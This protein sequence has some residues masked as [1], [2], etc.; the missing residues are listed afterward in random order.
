MSFDFVAADAVERSYE[1][2]PEV[3][4]NLTAA[5]KKI[6]EMIVEKNS[7]MPNLGYKRDRLHDEAD[8]FINDAQ[9]SLLTQHGDEKG[10][11]RKGDLRN[12]DH[13]AFREL[14]RANFGDEG[15]ETFSHVRNNMIKA[16]IKAPTKP[17]R[18]WW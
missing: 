8:R 12:I 9:S 14:V 5:V 18:W 13:G 2:T 1:T 16:P 17:S 3:M 4:S 6:K 15:L 11:Y 10:K 7:M